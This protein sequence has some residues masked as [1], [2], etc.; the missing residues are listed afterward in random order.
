[1]PGKLAW[2]VGTL[3]LT[4]LASAA[5]PVSTGEAV[6]ATGLLGLG[7]LEQMALRSNP[8][9]AQAAANIDAARGRTLQAGLYPNPTVGYNAEQL[10][11]RG[12]AAGGEQNGLFIDQTFVTAGKLRLNRA[13]SAQEASQ[14]EWQAQAQQYRV[15]NG[16]RSRYYQLLALQRLL[17]VQTELHQLAA[18]AVTTTEELVNVGA[19]N[20]PD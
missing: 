16:V 18:D 20:K 4:G 15:L 10:G 9:L 8:T 11:L 7:D 6:S 13:R 2:L 5:D 12:R 1:M 3:F 17:E 14:L 19:A